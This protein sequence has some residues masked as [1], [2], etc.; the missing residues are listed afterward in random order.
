M[1]FIIRE[2][3]VMIIFILIIVILAIILY[4]KNRKTSLDKLVM[5]ADGG[6]SEAQQEIGRMFENDESF[7]YKLCK[8]RIKVY[9]KMA[10]KG[11][12]FAMERVGFSLVSLGD[13]KGLSYLL[14]LANKGN[15]RAIKDLYIAYTEFGGLGD[16]PVEH[17]KWKKKAAELGDA[18]AQY[19][20][21]LRLNARGN[22]EEGNRWLKKSADQN[23]SPACTSYAEVILQDLLFNQLQKSDEEKYELATKVIDLAN[24]A[25]NTAEDDEEL[26]SAIAVLG[27]VLSENYGVQNI[28]AAAY[29]FYLAYDVDNMNKSALHSFERLKEKY[30]LSVDVNDM[31]AWKRRVLG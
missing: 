11:D 31:D 15:I 24:A 16:Q 26:S 4:L 7:E 1:K 20:W 21:G 14:S 13:E 17:D 29:Y 30:N 22:H 8:S 5:R 25:I 28:D 2:G 12:E 19:G 23:Y 6:D 3:E 10:N 18:E 27:S 9:S